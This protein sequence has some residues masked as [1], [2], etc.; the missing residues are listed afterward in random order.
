MRQ[1][2]GVCGII[3]AWLLLAGIS[4]ADPSVTIC[5]DDKLLPDQDWNGASDFFADVSDAPTPGKEC[6][7]SDPTYTWTVDDGGA[8]VDPTEGESTTVSLQDKM[9][10]GMSYTL[11][12]TVTWEE[13]S[14]GEGGD[15]PRGTITATDSMQVAA[16]WVGIDDIGN[17]CTGGPHTSHD[18]FVTIIPEGWDVPVTLDLTSQS[19]GFAVFDDSGTD[20]T[21]ITESQMVTID[22]EI[23]SD[24]EDDMEIAADFGEG[25]CV[26]KN[27]MVYDVDTLTARCGYHEANSA[28]SSEEEDGT[29][30]EICQQAEGLA[31]LL[32][33]LS[34]WP[35]DADGSMFLWDFVSAADEN[36][37]ADE[38]YEDNGDFGDGDVNAYWY[39]DDSATASREFYLRAWFDCEENGEF[40]D[41][42]P[43]RKIKIRVVDLDTLTLSDTQDESNFAIDETRDNEPM[44]VAN[45]LYLVEGTNGTAKMNIDL[46]WMP[47]SATV[48]NFH[49]EILQQG[50]KA[51]SAQWSLSNGTFAVANP[52]TVTW[53]N[54][55]NGQ[56]N[57][58]FIVNAWFDCNH[59]G[60]NDVDEPH[61]QLFVKILHLNLIPDFNHDGKID[62]T[63]RE[64][65]TTNGPFHF[66]INDTSYNYN[67]D[68]SSDNGGIPGA[69]TANYTKN[70]VQGRIDLV[71]FFPLW[72]DLHDALDNLPPSYGIEYKL[73]QNNGSVKFVYTDLTKEQVGDFLDKESPTY[74][75]RFDQ[76][77]YIADTIAV[78]GSGV[79]LSTD[80]LNKIMTDG[81]KGVLLVEGASATTAPL[82]LEILKNGVKVCEKQL[83]L[84]IRGIDQMYR[85]VN[86]RQGVAN[87]PNEPANYPDSLCNSK[88]LVFVH[89]YNVDEQAA[90]G[91]FA[92]MFKRFY[93]SGSQ[94]MFTGVTWF[95]NDSQHW[96]T[97]GN[98]LNYYVN[99]TH[100]FAAA[101]NLAS[102]VKTL[103]GQK[104]IAA[105]S[106]GNMVVSSAIRDHDLHVNSYFMLDAAVAQEAYDGTQSH[107]NMMNP[108]WDGY[109][110]R[111]WASE[112]YRLFASSDGRRQNLT[113]RNRFGAF[114]QAFNYYSTGE[115]VL[116]NGN[117]TVPNLTATIRA[118]VNQEMRKGT[119]M[120][121]AVAT[122]EGGWGF[123]N[124]YGKQ[125]VV[126]PGLTP[127]EANRLTAAQLR[128]NS[129]FKR[130]DI[131][132]LYGPN[133]SAEA[134]RWQVRAQLLGD[135]IPALSFA[136]GANKTTGLGRGES[137]MMSLESGWPQERLKD[138][139]TL[140]HWL[141]SDVKNVAFPFVHNLFED[142]IKEG[143]L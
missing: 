95:G 53:T 100:A 45:T 121:S 3:L 137:D 123:D 84:S 19:S 61:R 96:Y 130:F 136:T 87:A 49:F 57:R 5:G 70:S 69:G 37:P 138:R 141:H 50:G 65:I 44:S 22:G 118:W 77:A 62:E 8:S 16:L 10:W 94:A 72:L 38:W 114:S 7:L 64:Q 92:E 105:H 83:Q 128:A 55:V 32:F 52:A 68:I 33:N 58:V 81:S 9:G 79:A 106:L 74:G 46:S 111:L 25:S 47:A 1:K 103:P 117:G 120:I 129:F 133:G 35:D 109:A 51:P 71:N 39:P 43:S 104:Y 27:F 99:V 142:I 28:A 126:G 63:D 108:T 82:V 132:Q 4:Q 13:T 119:L 76:P 91:W 29:V 125:T 40:D 54:C 131:A 60:A 90:R 97:G 78:M 86:I 73:R 93:H 98:A 89:G 112:W 18:V 67:G 48:T 30:L 122:S 135:G 36:Q 134:R 42:A 102:A 88:Q 31:Q 6:K 2:L 66:W 85:M 56:S 41:T 101:P 143:D 116:A 139:T 80:F 14:T 110:P 23:A 15:I 59:D 127:A 12:V 124:A 140:N 17:I 34:Y 115:D 20:E 107:P 11:T 26:S 24:W 21:T 75:S 113:W